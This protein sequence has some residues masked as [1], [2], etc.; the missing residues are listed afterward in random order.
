MTTRFHGLTF[1]TDPGRVFSPRP[2]TEKL[3][4]AALERIGDG[5]ARVADIGTGSGA[6]AITLALR[7][8]TVEVWASDTCGNALAARVA[9]RRTARRAGAPRARRPARRDPARPRPDRREP[10][11]PLARHDRATTTSRRR[12][13]SRPATGSTTTAACSPRAADHLAPSGGDRDPV[14]RRS[15][16]GRAERAALAALTARVAGRRGGLGPRSTRHAVV[17]LG[18]AERR[19]H[20]RSNSVAASRRAARVTRPTSSTRGR[21]ASPPSRCARRR[22]R[23]PRR[24]RTASRRAARGRTSGVGFGGS[25][26]SS[27]VAIASTRD[28]ASLCVIESPSS[29]SWSVTSGSRS[30]I[31]SRVEPVERAPAVTRSKRPHDGIDVLGAADDR[32]DVRLRRSARASPARRRPPRPRRRGRR[33]R[34][35]RGPGRRRDRGRATAASSPAAGHEPLDQ[36]GRV[37]R[38]VVGVPRGCRLEVVPLVL[39]I[40]YCAACATRTG[41]PRWRNL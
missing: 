38:P 25:S 40:G 36:L 31:T 32:A 28:C 14:R 18:V 27:S 30:N 26:P 12:P 29:A 19:T 41:T 2:P 10:A 8:P 4:D 37:P 22:R 35:R 33:S 16:R 5:P 13:S 39:L 7:V 11:V 17:V 1:V 9:E 23:S 3:V 24:P 21:S 20:A 15:A 6:I 34:S